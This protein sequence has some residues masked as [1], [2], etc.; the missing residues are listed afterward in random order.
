MHY[1]FSKKGEGEGKKTNKTTK[2]PQKQH[3]LK[4]TWEK[5]EI[6]LGDLDQIQPWFTWHRWVAAPGSC[7]SPPARSCPEMQHGSSQNCPVPGALQSQ[8][9]PKLL[10]GRDRQVPAFWA[11]GHTQLPHLPRGTRKKYLC[12]PCTYSPNLCP[13]NVSGEFST[14]F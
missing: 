3:L 8:R 12:F 6:R 5:T 11:N 1:S 4:L 14:D 9:L 13:T 10:S 7:R 2:T